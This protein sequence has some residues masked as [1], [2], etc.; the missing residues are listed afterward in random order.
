MTDL[1]IYTEDFISYCQ[2]RKNTEQQT[3]QVSLI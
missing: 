3:D 2:F 1:S